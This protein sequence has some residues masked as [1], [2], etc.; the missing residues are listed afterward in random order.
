[1][2]LNKSTRYALYAAMEMTLARS[3]PVTVG[4]I[5]RRY[6]IPEG[7]LA[8]VFQQLVRAGVAHGTRGVGGGY[9]LARSPAEVTVRDV[10]ELFEP[11]RR[12]GQCLLV[13]AGTGACDDLPTCRLRRLFDEVDELVRSTFASVSLETLAAGAGLK[14][15]GDRKPRTRARRRPEAG[16]RAPS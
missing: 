8:K 7:A 15:D 3:A 11:S 13:E 6:R 12:E 5:A 14:H 16:E 1:M 2:S 10:I 9:R 4:G